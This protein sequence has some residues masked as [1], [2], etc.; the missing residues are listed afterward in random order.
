MSYD[1]TG[2]A[3]RLQ[4]ARKTKGLSQREL[5]ALAGVPQAQISR[6]E[7][8]AVD[9]RLSSL[10][11]LAHAL[12]LELAL[13]PRKAVAV[14][15]SL[16]RDAISSN[17]KDVVAIQKEMQRISET[18]RGIQMSMPDLEGLQR[19][20]KS[21]SDLHRFRVSMLDLEEM[22]KLRHIIE[23]IG[24]PGK[25]MVSLNESLKIMRT[26]RNKAS[27]D[28]LP[29]SGDTL[30]RPAYSLDEEDDDA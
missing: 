8:G 16:S 14:V 24:R 6:I 25:E 12:D 19:L 30:S 3:E 26:I 15:R 28:P 10:A 18:M 27:H 13:V 29:D 2:I 4:A 21:I 9:L 11:A 17:R 23:Q 7:A 20:Q 22:K 1:I 5:S